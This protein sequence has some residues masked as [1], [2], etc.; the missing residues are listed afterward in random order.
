M[1]GKIDPYSEPLPLRSEAQAISELRYILSGHGGHNLPVD[2]GRMARVRCGDVT[3]V[4]TERTG[5]GSLPE[6]YRADG[7]E[8]RDF[9]VVLAK[10]PGGFRHDYEPFAAGILFCAGQ[11]CSP[12]NLLSLSY[13]SRSA[14]LFLFDPIADPAEATWAG[15]LR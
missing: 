3:L 6:L 9:K 2:M 13:R 5:P 1:G 14:P 7:A 11:G 4:L 8:P 12:P 10:S 15:A